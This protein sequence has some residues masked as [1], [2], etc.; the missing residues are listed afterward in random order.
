MSSRLCYKVEKGLQILNKRW[1]CLIIYQLQSGP[2]RFGE[3]QSVIGISKRLLSE[4]LKELEE[5]HIV[6]REMIVDSSAR[7]VYA[8]TEKGLALSPA[9][10]E[11]EKWSRA[12]IEDEN[13]EEE[14]EGL[15]AGQG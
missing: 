7:I 11:I 1:T 2:Q 13:E 10:R 15:N 9:V 3:I 12:W 5:D 14:N 8:L 4:R 6:K